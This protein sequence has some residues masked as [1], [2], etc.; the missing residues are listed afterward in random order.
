META[1]GANSGLDWTLDWTGHIQQL[2]IWTSI[3]ITGPYLER[4]QGAVAPDYGNDDDN[5]LGSIAIMHFTY[6][7]LS[8][9]GT[10]PFRVGAHPRS[11]PS[12]YGHAVHDHPP[13]SP[14]KFC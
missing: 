3:H 13:P 10:S 4:G 8:S 1:W 9:G 5:T 7:P 6:V 11:A 12:L 2:L 14:L